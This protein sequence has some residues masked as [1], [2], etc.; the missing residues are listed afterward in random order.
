MFV[1]SV[2]T[3]S[4]RIK[5]F[6]CFHSCTRENVA[7]K[8]DKKASCICVCVHP[9]NF[10]TAAFT[11]SLSVCPYFLSDSS[12][13]PHPSFLTMAILIL[14]LFCCSQF[15]FHPTSFPLGWLMVCVFA[16]LCVCVSIREFVSTVRLARP[17]C[18]RHV[19]RKIMEVL[20]AP[21]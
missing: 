5:S 12:F 16:C 14:C 20:S 9:M 7:T 3:S 21:Q 19:W 4:D 6:V 10:S 13:L 17:L 8:R 11:L 15:L 1:L 2:L 18:V